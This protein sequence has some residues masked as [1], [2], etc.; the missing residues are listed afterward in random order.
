MK[1]NVIALLAGILLIPLTLTGCST[2]ENS[3]SGATAT[4]TPSPSV[5][6][7]QESDL[8]KVSY[9][10]YCGDQ[11][12]GTVLVITSDRK[13]KQYD[14]TWDYKYPDLLDRKSVV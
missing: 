5:T 1:K 2:Q 14:I 10:G 13:V 6:G 4:S 9:I 3:S 12:C 7:T 8:T 11:D